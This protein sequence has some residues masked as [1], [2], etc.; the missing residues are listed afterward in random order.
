MI[1]ALHGIVLYI[2]VCYNTYKSIYFTDVI[3]TAISF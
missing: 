3:C 1:Y 2:V